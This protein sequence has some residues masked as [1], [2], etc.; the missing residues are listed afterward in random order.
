MTSINWGDLVSKAGQVSSSQN[1]EP[2][3][4]GIYDM[5]VLEASQTVAASGKTMFKVTHEVQ[6]GPHNKRRVWDNLVVTPDNETALNIF[7]SK[8]DAMGLRKEFF[9]PSTSNAQIENALIGKR[10]R[11]KIG[12]RKWEGQDRNEVKSYMASSNVPSSSNAESTINYQNNQIA[13][14]PPP[15]RGIATSS[16]NDS[17]F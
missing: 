4:D 3:P 7:F 9:T 12:T 1:Y 17:P 14:P 11:A 15:P 5:M 8:M 10:F 6:G 2:I 16:F 13:A